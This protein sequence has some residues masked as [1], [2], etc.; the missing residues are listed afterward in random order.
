VLWAR[1]VAAWLVFVPGS[2]ITVRWLGGGELGAVVW[3]ALYL[4]LLAAALY[5]RFRKGTWRSLE[6]LEP[7]LD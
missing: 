5:A 6:V 2:Y 4:A 7:Q 3:L 1:L